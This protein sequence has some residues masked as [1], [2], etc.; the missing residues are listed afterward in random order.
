MQEGPG[1]EELPQ[2]AVA[3]ARAEKAVEGETGLLGG[4]E[5]ES[6]WKVLKTSSRVK[7]I[8]TAMKWH[9][10]E[11]RKYSGA[12][13]VIHPAAVAATL[14]TL[15]FEDFVVN[16]GW[17]HDAV[18]HAVAMGKMTLEEA[19]LA[20]ASELGEAIATLVV[21]VTP[22]SLGMSLS[23]SKRKELDRAHYASASAIGQS[24]HLADMLDNVRDIGAVAPDFARVY[25]REKRAEWESLTLADARLI[26]LVDKELRTQGH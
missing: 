24:L 18:E 11:T 6:E 21:E 2:K 7:A 8:Q 22:V 23:R 19:R 3:S 4:I 1:R 26:D 25:L 12:P 15:G 20:L 5:D 10:G 9:E 17:V 13:F 14:A 16:A